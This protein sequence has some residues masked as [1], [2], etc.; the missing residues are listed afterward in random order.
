MAV[1]RQ[2][3]G[4]LG[5][6]FD[7]VHIAHVALAE[8][9]YHTLG[10]NKVEL[11]PAGNPWQRAPLSADKQHRLAMLKLAIGQ[12][13]WLH[14]NTMEIERRGPTYTID[15]LKE[16]PAGPDYYWILGSDQLNNFCSWHAW[17]DITQ[18]VYLVVARRPE[19]TVD[20]PEPLQQYLHSIDKKI[21]HLPFSP[22]A[23][24]AT[25]IRERLTQGKPADRFLDPAVA[26]YIRQHRLYEGD[27]ETQLTV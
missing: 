27:V 20:A 4:L 2:K 12:R 19:S 13:A 16:L 23:I 18:R 9:A 25:E 6:S 8:T 5:G 21:I 22:Q 24:S 3:I 17:R 15:T 1:I 14:I 10:L 7:P 26:A 11:I